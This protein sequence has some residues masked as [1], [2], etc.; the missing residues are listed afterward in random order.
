MIKP[1][2][3]RKL[4]VFG[5]KTY[6]KEVIETMYDLNVVHIEDHTK[7]NE[8]EFFDIGEPFKENEKF[9]ELLVKLRTIISN[10]NIK[11]N[12]VKKSTSSINIIEKKT[13]EVYDQVNHLLR[14]KEYYTSLKKIYDSKEV[15][16]SL[17]S[18]KIDESED[19]DY[20][21]LKHYFGYIDSNQ[22]NLRESIEKITKKYTL[23]S[24]NY[25]GALLIGL[26]VDEKKEEKVKELLKSNDFSP[27]DNPVIKEQYDLKSKSGVKF[28]KLDKEQEVVVNELQKVQNRLNESK[29]ENENFLL[30]SE[31]LLRIESEKAEAP[32]RFASSKNTFL[33]NGWVPKK[34]IKKLQSSLND[35]TDNKV[36]VEFHK[37][38]KKDNV[39]IAFNHPKFVEPFEAFMD[40]YSLPSY[41]EIDPTF[42]MFLTFP[43][44]FGFMLGDVG[45][46]LVILGLFLF[47]RKKMPGAKNFINSFIIAAIVSIAFGMVFGEYFGYEEVSP[48]LGRMLGIHA[49]KVVSHG[50]T[51]IKYVIPHL[52]ARSHRMED[53]LSLAILFGIVH[54]LIGYL[55]GFIN[56]YKAH[57]L[58]HAIME[59]VGW[60]LLFPGVIYLLTDFLGVV[61][62][63]VAVMLKA[64][65]PSMP[66]LI[67]LSIFGIL[68]VIKGEGAQGAVEL[69]ALISNILSYARLMAVGLASLSLAVVVNNMAG[70]MFKS[71]IVGVFA[72][73]MIL[74]L[75]HTINIA[76][77]ILS[78]F[79][80]SLRLHYV[81]FFTKFFKGGGKKFKSFG[82]TQN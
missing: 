64:F 56:I 74:V 10:L 2:T 49:E 17:K 41:K 60:M 38:K 72:G 18:L 53:L 36:H 14:K 24:T 3:M 4:T 79:L 11:K 59:K 77:G 5:P 76:L 12:Q 80:H 48:G 44:F 27:I 70:D 8:D 39:P 33:V 25:Q 68:V 81:E 1:K 50:V 16:K 45:Y 52:F 65:V 6:L 54:V 34:N 51:E 75:G 82:Q 78:P 46:G 42:F 55:I 19:V 20:N 63:F 61:T 66:I 69:P 73:I 15:L 23:Y 28:V 30:Q 67:G 21:G 13:N 71:G 31:C 58:K 22:D 32:L 35:V 9:A 62:G 43:I 37:P 57:G 29:S 26:F 7:K 47:L 40:L